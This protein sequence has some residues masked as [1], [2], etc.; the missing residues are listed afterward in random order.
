M[1]KVLKKA[2]KEIIELLPVVIFFFLAFN[3]IVLTDALT[4]EQYGIRV[5]SFVSASIA[6]L[7]VGNVVFLANILPFMNR[8]HGKPLIYNTLW[9]TFIYMFISLIVRYLEHLIPFVFKYKSLVVANDHFMSEMVWPR[10]WAIQ[11]WLIVLFFVFAAFQEL[12]GVL[13]NGRVRQMFFG[14]PE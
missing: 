12:V 8:F 4:T 3:L 13:G 9:K 2:K 7:V 10:F 11:I 6:A 5:F 1:H 14:R